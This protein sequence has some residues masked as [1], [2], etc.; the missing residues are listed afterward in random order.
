[1]RRSCK[2]NVGRLK[3][4]VMIVIYSDNG[5]AVRV[6]IGNLCGSNIL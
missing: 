4:Q 5:R 6:N 2:F 1:M 3:R